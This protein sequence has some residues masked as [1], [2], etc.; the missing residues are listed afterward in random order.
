MNRER[1]WRLSAQAHRVGKLQNK[2]DTSF[3]FS[4]KSPAKSISSC[5]FG[6]CFFLGY[7]YDLT[8]TSIIA[9][10]ASKQSRKTIVTGISTLFAVTGYILRTGRT[11][12]LR[13]SGQGYRFWR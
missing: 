3:I 1:C 6:R 10:I 12:P 7:F 11:C 4:E 8:T 13:Y 2:K 9:V 5:Q